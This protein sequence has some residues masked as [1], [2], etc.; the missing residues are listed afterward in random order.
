VAGVLILLAAG[1][2]GRMTT[3]SKQGKQWATILLAGLLLFDGWALTNY[4]FSPDPA[5]R[6]AP[7]WR[8]LG[9][10]LKTQVHP[11]DFV[12][13][14]A[15]DPA[16]TYYLD[17]AVPETTLPE[18]ANAPAEETIAI[19]E[20]LLATHHAIW[21]IPAEIP[22][23]DPDHVPLT[24][25]SQQAQT[26][27]NVEVA[28]FE[29]LEFQPWEVNPDEYTSRFEF[30]FSGSATLLD[31]KAEGLP[32]ASTL[33]VTLYWQTVGQTDQPLSAFMHFVGPPSESESAPIWAQDDHTLRYRTMDSTGWPEGAVFRDV[34]HIPLDASM[35][36]G[37]WTLHVG[38]YDPTTLERVQV[39]DAD[40]VE[41]PLPTEFV[42]AD[43]LAD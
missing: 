27:T 13:Q 42:P 26:T 3:R 19:L 31:W 28:G 25:L 37:P 14:Q 4:Y 21:L 32:N 36:S 24:W 35:P 12:V 7:D 18:Y 43:Y 34:Y 9:A 23:Y 8:A 2:I 6:K 17:D 41:F 1:I 16:F 15:V 11:D 29:V 22:N 40:H 38:L 10:F 33:R 30:T 5:Y 20:D 39:G